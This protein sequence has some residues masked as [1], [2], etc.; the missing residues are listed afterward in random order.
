ML[1]GV[2]LA[3][4]SLLCYCSFAP[5]GLGPLTFLTCAFQVWIVDRL[6]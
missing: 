2:C 4:L 1:K 5:G 6:K 3:S